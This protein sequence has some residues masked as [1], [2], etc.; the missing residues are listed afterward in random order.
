MRDRFKAPEPMACEL[1]EHYLRRVVDALEEWA[2]QPVT[3]TICR[4]LTAL[5]AETGADLSVRVE[6]TSH[7][8]VRIEEE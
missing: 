3:F 2:N 8:V 5:A 7:I 1:Y 6:G 4:K